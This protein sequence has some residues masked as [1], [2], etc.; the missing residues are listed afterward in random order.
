MAQSGNGLRSVSGSEREGISEPELE[1]IDKA[2]DI[3]NG[4][5]KK[6]GKEDDNY[7]QLDEVFRNLGLDIPRNKS[8]KAYRDALKD[9]YGEEFGEREKLR[10]GGRWRTAAKVIVKLLIAAA[11]GGIVAAFGLGTMIAIL[12]AGGAAGYFAYQHKK[13]KRGMIDKAV[14]AIMRD[15][16]KLAKNGHEI[17]ASKQ[18]ITQKA[19]ERA[20][21][22]T[23]NRMRTPTTQL[24]IS[25]A[26]D[27][28]LSSA[29]LSI[30]EMT[31]F[32]S[33]DPPER[34]AS[35]PSPAQTVSPEVRKKGG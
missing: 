25:A 20:S 35:L 30:S 15:S 6:R 3:L 13:G 32:K 9:T 11:V 34:A 29:A 7:A 12:A 22:A 17:S 1:G 21:T 27:S 24:A 4:I 28:A 31:S 23:A 16:G 5:D 26:A 2:I 8:S 19:M 10:N 18:R 14:D 33:P